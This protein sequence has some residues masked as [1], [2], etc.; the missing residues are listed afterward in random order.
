MKGDERIFVD[1]EPNDFIVRISPILDEDDAWT[2]DLRVGYMTIEENYLK[3]DDYNHVDFLTNLMLASV[4]LM[5]LDESFR[6]R[7]YKHHESVLKSSSKPTVLRKEDN[8]VHLDFGNE[9]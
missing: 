8:V 9:Q 1:F 2:G 4:P 3:E 6:D 7:L 5:E